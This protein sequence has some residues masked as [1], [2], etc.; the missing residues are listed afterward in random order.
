M[1]ARKLK[2]I[3]IAGLAGLATT[4][5][6]QVPD[7]LNA[8]DSGGRAMGMGGST[9][10]TDATTQ[11]ALDNPAGL[12]YI[13]ER[14]AAA[15]LRNLP[16]SENV[17]SG[18]FGDR[19]NN[20]ELK[21]GKMSV[22]HVGYAT[23]FGGGT[24]GVSYT[25]GGYVN[26]RTVGNNLT[27]GPLTVRNLD[28]TT[29]AQTDF[30]TL[31]YGKRQGSMNYGIGIVV[32]NQ[33]VRFAQSFQLF[34]ASN[35]QVGSTSTDASGNA[36]GVGVVAGVQGQLSGGVD[37]GL[38]VR[39]PIDLGGNATTSSIYDKIPGKASLGFAGVMNGMSAGEDYLLWAMQ[40]DYYFGGDGS[41]AIPRKN[42]AAFAGGIEYNMHRF[43]ARIP[44][45][46]GY[47]HIPSGGANFGDR[48]AFTFGIGYRPNNADYTIDLSFAKPTDGN[49][50]DLA[51]GITFKPSK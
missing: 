1:D 38:S 48:S 3:F 4:G 51:L 17:A 36:L 25:V 5:F 43:N 35:T 16:N 23:K 8:L 31:S 46:L 33:Y 9:R 28:E 20:T 24:L 21:T 7:L 12:A 29:K 6:A 44:I 22:S 50:F 45:R 2:T 41:A 15:N 49:K 26:N 32:A 14:S 40:A 47:Q 10:V 37:W 34:D 19:T 11:S 13:T 42:V 30:F 39:T 18:Q 27:D